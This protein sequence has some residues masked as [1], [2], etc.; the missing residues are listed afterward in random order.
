MPFP[1]P[2]SQPLRFRSSSID[3]NINSKRGRD[4]SR[5]EKQFVPCV[6]ASSSIVEGLPPRAIRKEQR[7]GFPDGS[8]GF[9]S[10]RFQKQ[11]VSVVPKDSGQAASSSFWCLGSPSWRDLGFQGWI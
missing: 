1:I 10:C 9:P 6:L 11:A 8:P 2:A 4:G 3:I 7:K 5:R